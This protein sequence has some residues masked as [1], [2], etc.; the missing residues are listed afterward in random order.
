MPDGGGRAARRRRQVLIDETVR[1]LL[2]SAGSTAICLVLV[3]YTVSFCHSPRDV[4]RT[5]V[6]SLRPELTRL[7][8]SLLSIEARMPEGHETPLAAA[9]KTFYHGM[10][11]SR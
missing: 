10:E 3:R 8:Q 9:T 7:R 2:H 5:G 1:K 11:N 6:A 4:Y